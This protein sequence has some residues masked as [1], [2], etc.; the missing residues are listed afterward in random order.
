MSVKLTACPQCDAPAEVTDY[1][2]VHSTDGLVRTLQV[3]CLRRHWFLLAE[4]SLDAPQ[5]AGASR[6]PRTAVLS[7][8][9]GSLDPTGDTSQGTVEP[10]PRTTP[11]GREEPRS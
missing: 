7:A 4:D 3:R 11:A 5:G 1:G 10:R 9:P 2:L 8:P 6:V